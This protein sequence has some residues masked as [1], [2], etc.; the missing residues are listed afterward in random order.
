MY[1]SVFSLGLC[2]S[3]GWLQA[4]HSVARPGWGP[5]FP[6]ELQAVYCQ[7]PSGCYENMQ[8]CTTPATARLHTLQLAR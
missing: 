6:A 2:S 3:G 4:P 5:P 7:V 8:H 1:Q